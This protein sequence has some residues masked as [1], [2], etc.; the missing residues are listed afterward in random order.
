[1]QHR[2]L[3]KREL[4]QNEERAKKGVRVQ[5]MRVFIKLLKCKIE[6]EQQR[7]NGKIKKCM[8]VRANRL[9]RNLNDEV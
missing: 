6:V 7:T 2:F 5:E 1:M 4:V 8:V 9:Y 3:T